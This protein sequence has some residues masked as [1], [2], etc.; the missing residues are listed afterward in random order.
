MSTGLIY[1][2]VARN[3]AIPVSSGQLWEISATASIIIRSISIS[4]IPIVQAFVDVTSMASLQVAS[5]S[6]LGTGGSAV[7]PAAQDPR[8]TVG[9]TT[10]FRSLVT[11][12][13]AVL[14][15]LT[16]SNVRADLKDDYQALG[17]YGLWRVA[18]LPMSGGSRLGVLITG[19]TNNPF[20]VTSVIE[21]E[22]F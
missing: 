22:E 16:A 11:T 2:A 17:H 6:S 1:T 5:L 21:F 15:V 19:D 18:G 3:I 12:P 4:F 10:S 13:G 20:S 8:N 7:T 9:A 14:S